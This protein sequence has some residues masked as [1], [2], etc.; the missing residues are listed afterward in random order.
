MDLAANGQWY[1]HDQNEDDGEIA[2]TFRLRTQT[3][4][5]RAERSGTGTGRIYTITIT[6]T[7]SAGNV[8]TANAEMI[9]RKRSNFSICYK[10]TD[11]LA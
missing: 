6:A 10:C 1:E 9:A 8:S 11:F 4:N 2:T 5:L 3:A 7:D